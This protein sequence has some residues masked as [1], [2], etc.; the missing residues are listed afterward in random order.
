MAEGYLGYVAGEF[1]RNALF[2]GEVTLAAPQT[3]SPIR[4]IREIR[5]SITSWS[6]CLACFSHFPGTSGDERLI[7]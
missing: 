1:G 4:P 6:A 5:G 7:G 2:V 3:Q